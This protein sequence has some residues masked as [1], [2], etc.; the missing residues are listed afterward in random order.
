MDLLV[1]PYCG[2]V[3]TKSGLIVK[4]G[5]VSG[6]SPALPSANE[7]HDGR[8][9]CPA[10]K[11]TLPDAQQDVLL[12]NLAHVIPSLSAADRLAVAKILHQQAVSWDSEQPP[13]EETIAAV[14]PEAGI[15]GRLAPRDRAEFLQYVAIILSVLA[16]ADDIIANYLVPS[17]ASL[18]KG[19]VTQSGD[20]PD[21]QYDDEP[22]YQPDY[23]FDEPDDEP[24]NEITP[25]RMT[26]GYVQL[27]GS[28]VRFQ[29]QVTL[30]QSVLWG[31]ATP[32]GNYSTRP[33]IVAS[34]SGRWTWN[35]DAKK[36]DWVWFFSSYPWEVQTI[37]RLSLRNLRSSYFPTHNF[38][39]CRIVHLPKN[40][41]KVK[42]QASRN[43]ARRRW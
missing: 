35:V 18:P 22:D 36:Y 13:L 3:S 6:E 16:L 37:R 9:H 27:P 11:Q 23:K 17:T 4:L 10:C 30:W 8:Y 1:C 12:E 31:L 24:D 20:Q 32:D 19:Y 7:S 42:I 39:R 34:T 14:A 25:E 29:G 15:I 43:A 33:H 21:N 2:A 28:I 41:L 5:T 38:I 26:V 40:K